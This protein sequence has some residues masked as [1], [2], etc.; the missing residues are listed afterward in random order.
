MSLFNLK[1]LVSKEDFAD[2]HE[3]VNDGV[4]KVP[5]AADI[6]ASVKSGEGGTDTSNAGP[7]KI[8]PEKE[9]T[10]DKTEKQFDTVSEST[11]KG[12]SDKPASAG[13]PEAGKPPFTPKKDEASDTEKDDAPAKPPFPPKKDEAAGDE[14]KSEPVDAPLEHE[15]K[16]AT[17]DE[18]KKT[19]TVTKSLEDYSVHA[20]RFD[21]VGYPKVEG[22]RIKKRMN[23][24]ASRTGEPLN[25]TISAESINHMVDVG[26]KRG[27]ALGNQVKVHEQRKA[28]LESI[29]DIPYT[30]APEVPAETNIDNLDVDLGAGLAEREIDP[31]DV[32]IIGINQ[33]AET[34]EVLENA[35]VAIEKHISILRNAPFISQQAAA[36]LQAGLEHIDR[37]CGLKVRATGLEGYDTSPRSAMA[38]AD[39]SIESLNT[40]AADIGAKILKWIAQILEQASTQWHKYQA[41]LTGILSDAR[42]VKD[43]IDGLKGNP[44]KDTLVLKTNS[45]MYL[46]SEFVGNTIHSSVASAPKFLK[47]QYSDLRNDLVGDFTTILNSGDGDTLERLKQVDADQAESTTAELELPGGVTLVRKGLTIEVERGDEPAHPGAV[48]VD[49]NRTEMRRQIAASVKFLEQLGDGS[50]LAVIK[51]AQES[52]GKVLIAFRKGAGKDLEETERQ[53]I[54]SYVIGKATKTFSVSSYFTTISYLTKQAATVVRLHEAMANAWGEGSDE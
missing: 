1:S 23:W 25:Q 24:L 26:R 12:G 54:Q 29:G 32:G 30:P 33:V 36:V 43:Q 11:E 40:R 42:K 44:G 5:T 49:L 41:G 13:K 52:I 31:L 20:S 9:E 39:I 37:V 16:E 46:G 53:Q 38:K 2:S 47:T 10:G 18:Q 34:L 27:I 7:A 8:I 45:N 50:T 51:G 48:E 4:K 17:E 3:P 15:T 35:Q 14:E 28:A 19:D 21:V 22:E 6:A